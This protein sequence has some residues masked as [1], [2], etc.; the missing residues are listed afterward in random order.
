MAQERDN[1]VRRCKRNN[2]TRATFVETDEGVSADF[3]HGSHTHRE[4]YSVEQMIAY[5]ASKGYVVVEA[6]KLFRAA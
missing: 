5:L 1:Q 3:R 2:C 6:A 4:V